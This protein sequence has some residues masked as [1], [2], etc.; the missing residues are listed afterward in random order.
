MKLIHYTDVEANVVGVEGAKNVTMRMLISEPDGAPNFR[1]RFFEVGPGGSTPYHQHP[2]EHEVFVVEGEG[3]CVDEARNE[4][5]V[6]SGCAVFI[7]PNEWHCLVNKG[8]TALKFLCIVPTEE[9]QK[10]RATELGTPRE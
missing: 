6:W 4:H 7:P 10:W 3:A 8:E 1:M 2:W 5:P 9:V